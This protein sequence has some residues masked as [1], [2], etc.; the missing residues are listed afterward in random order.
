MKIIWSVLLVLLLLAAPA[1]VQAQYAYSTNAD[2][3]IYAYTTNTDGSINIAG[4]SGPPW[5]V[6]IPTNINNL[7]VTSIGQVAYYETGLTSVTISG[8]VANIAQAAFFGCSSLASVTILTEGGTTIGNYAFSDC[9]NLTNVTMSDGVASIES[10]AFADT[11]LATVTIPASV[12]NIDPGPFRDCISLTAIVVA[13]NNPYY[14]DLNGVLFD[15]GQTTLIQ[16]PIGIYG[17]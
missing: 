6:T 10:G 15:K 12:T 11:G 7:L 16:Y 3:S 8:G 5:A 9:P 4:Y 13:S 14:S 2:G 17:G 1:A